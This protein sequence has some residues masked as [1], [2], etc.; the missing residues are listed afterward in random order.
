MRSF[1][2]IFI[3]SSKTSSHLSAFSLYPTN[4]AAVSRLGRTV[5]FVTVYVKP[6][7]SVQG[8]ES[9]KCLYMPFR[10]PN[11]CLQ[12]GQRKDGITVDSLTEQR[13]E[14]LV[15]L[16]ANDGTIT[17]VNALC[18]ISSINRKKILMFICKIPFSTQGMLII[19]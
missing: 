12:V 2:D 5:L 14:T 6:D 7:D 18:S 1:S 3:C 15:L 8:G 13:L 17:R 4:R 9:R 19:F 11:P 16:W 10:L